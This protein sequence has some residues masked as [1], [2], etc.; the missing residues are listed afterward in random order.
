MLMCVAMLL[1]T[2]AEALEAKGICCDAHRRLAS[3]PLLQKLI[4]A[5]FNIKTRQGSITSD[6]LFCY[7]SK[8]ASDKVGTAETQLLPGQL[9]DWLQ[10]Q[11]SHLH[12]SNTAALLDQLLLCTALIARDNPAFEATEATFGAVQSIISSTGCLSGINA[13]AAAFTTET[14][15]SYAAAAA[16]FDGG[17]PQLQRH[18]LLHQMAEPSVLMQAAEVLAGKQITAGLQLLSDALL[19]G[20]ADKAVQSQQVLHQIFIYSLQQMLVLLYRNH[21]SMPTAAQLIR[22]WMADCGQVIPAAAAKAFLGACGQ[23]R[24]DLQ[25]DLAAV[26]LKNVSQAEL[27]AATAASVSQHQ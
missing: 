10:Q 1:S 27:L 2:P 14:V 22:I 16:S 20:C 25:P 26:L 19:S 21:S 7:C 15:A 6:Q 13:A 5:V 17:S 12:P 23:H 8:P 24:S 18:L 4:A 3:L 11:A 9:L